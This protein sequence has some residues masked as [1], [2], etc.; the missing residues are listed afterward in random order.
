VFLVA[1]SSSDRRLTET[2]AA[3]R[4]WVYATSVMGVTGARTQTS[5]AAPA[6]VQR[7]REIAPG[8]RVGVGLGISNGAQAAEVNRYADA[9]IVGSA[10]V[11]ALIAADDADRP[12]DLSGLRSVVADLAAGVRN[13]VPSDQPPGDPTEPIVDQSAISG[14]R[15]T[16]ESPV[17]LTQR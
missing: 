2:V 13:P 5:S 11:G 1:P 3:C 16:S 6:L 9:A 15:G 4:G 7:V 12:D 8:A 10:L 14:S 17:R